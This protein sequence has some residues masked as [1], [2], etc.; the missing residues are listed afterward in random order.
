MHL[1]RPNSGR[2]TQRSSRRNELRT[3]T[4]YRQSRPKISNVFNH[5]NLSTVSTDISAATSGIAYATKDPRIMQLGM[6]LNF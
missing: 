1:S 6:K 3:E 4:P 2:N 5:T